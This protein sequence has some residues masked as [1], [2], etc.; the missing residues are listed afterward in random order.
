M[1]VKSLIAI[2]MLCLYTK[3]NAECFHKVGIAY[4]LDPDYLRAI[5]YKESRF[6]PKAIGKNNDGTRDIGIMQVNTG[7]LEWL[8]K[9]FPSISIK[10]LLENPCYNIHVGAYI[11]NENFKL[12]GR[13]WIAV[14]AYNAGGKNNPRR[15]KIRHQ[16]ALSISGYYRKIKSG[17]LALPKIRL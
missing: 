5:A 13:R 7:N 10:K 15:I 4:R 12:Y 16:Y 1:R 8:R 2:A 17:K 3:A 9:T 14:G 6:N 11:L